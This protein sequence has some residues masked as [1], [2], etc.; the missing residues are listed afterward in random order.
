MRE[1]PRAM[2]IALVTGWVVAS[3]TL[4]AYLVV[5]AKEPRHEECMDCR[6]PDC[7]E[8]PYFGESAKPEVLDHAA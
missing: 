5:T 4:Y 6:L 7:R 2:W 3:V 1:D 8:C